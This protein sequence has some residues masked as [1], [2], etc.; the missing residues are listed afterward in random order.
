[1]AKT[2][3]EISELLTKSAE[4]MKA[5][6]QA[7]AAQAVKNLP[8]AETPGPFNLGTQAPTLTGQGQNQR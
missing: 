4:R 7:A 8:E 5:V 1:M 3:F 2:K 6:N